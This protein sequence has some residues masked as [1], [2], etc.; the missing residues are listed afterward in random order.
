MTDLPDLVHIA[1][2]DNVC[3]LCP[4]AGGSIVSWTIGGQDMFRKTNEAAIVSHNALTFSSFPLVP[5]SNRIAFGTFVWEGQ[6]YDV[7]PNFAPEPHAIHGVG[8]ERAWHNIAQSDAGCTL[9]LMYTDDVQWPWGFSAQQKIT[10]KENTLELELIT[11]NL[12]NEPAPLAFGHH[13]YFD[14]EGATLDFDAKRVFMSDPLALPTKAV[15]P[16]GQFNFTGGAAVHDR[17]VDNCYADWDG[18]CRIS[19]A[20]RPLKL[21]ITSD[22]PATV[23]YIPEGGDAFC[24]EPV[25]HINNALNLIDADP[26]MPII[27]PGESHK[28]VIRFEAVS[29]DL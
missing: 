4:A 3:T 14:S 13:P 9:A 2:G 5:Y 24:F 25:P 28:A 6:Q 18:V 29:V 1:D 26:A 15:A 16:E 8:W 7:Q 17:D 19:W 23:V 21:I 12:A 11:T 27:M 22:M 10:V 20:N